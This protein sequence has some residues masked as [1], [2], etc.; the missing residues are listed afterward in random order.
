MDFCGSMGIFVVL[1]VCPSIVG[2]LFSE[3]VEGCDVGDVDVADAASY[4]SRRHMGQVL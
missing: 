1:V 2:V 4:G 3:V